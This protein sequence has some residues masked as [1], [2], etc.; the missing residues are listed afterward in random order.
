[1]ME[2]RMQGHWIRRSLTV[3]LL[4]GAQTVTAQA[5]APTAPATASGPGSIPPNA[6]R[7][8]AD[9]SLVRA[10]QDHEWTLRSATAADGK[11]VDGLLVTS[12]PFVLRFRDGRVSVNGGCNTM[13]ARWRLSPQNALTVARTASTQMACEPALMAADAAMAKALEQPLQARVDTAAGGASATL[14]LVTSTQQTL[15]FDGRRT[16]TS[17]FGAPT[18]VFLEVAAQRVPC[19]PA[20]QPPTTCLQVREIRFDDKGLRV[21]EPGPWRAFYGE[22]AGYTHEPG[23]ANVLRINR[24]T[25]QKPPA[26]ASAYVYELDMVIESR[27]EKK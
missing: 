16:L 18:R 10:L 25:R 27:T 11:P 1:M 7:R 12:K 14:H 20:L 23:T 4:T 21:G 5:P 17:Q 9:A 19:T 6:P 13:N 24:Y 2:I 26:D 22:I 8:T 15:S 3:L